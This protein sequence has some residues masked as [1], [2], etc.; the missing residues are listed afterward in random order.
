MAQANSKAPS[1]GI[2]IWKAI[3]SVQSMI[4]KHLLDRKSDLVATGDLFLVIP[5]YDYA[6]PLPSGFIAMA[7]KPCAFSAP[8]WLVST[9]W[10]AG[11]VTSYDTT[12]RTCIMN[13]T[14]FNGSGTVSVWYLAVGWRPGYPINT[15]DTSESSVV[16]GLGPKTF[17]T[18][19]VLAI[20]PGQNII[21]SNV[22][23]PTDS[24]PMSRLDPSYLDDDDHDD[25]LWWE[26]Y[27]LY[28][29]TWETAAARPRHFKVL[30]ST[31]FVRPKVVTPVM[32]TGKYNTQPV[33]FTE[34][35]YTATIPWNGLFDEIFREGTAWILQKGISIPEADPA[36]MAFFGREFGYVMNAKSTMIPT[37]NRTR[38]SNFM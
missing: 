24:I 15:V 17:I 27:K 26:E 3:N 35:V 11:T 7:E 37:T 20:T 2:T 6:A 8:G 38:R 29:Q 12:T 4:N 10:M 1:S 34:G 33:D 5:A 25:Y 32:I 36:F 18:D 13:V 31:L 23:I 30:G 22:E 14:S 19:K 28:G 21:L 16:V 9:P